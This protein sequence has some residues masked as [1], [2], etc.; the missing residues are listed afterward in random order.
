VL[1]MV[2]L[3]LDVTRDSGTVPQ[4]RQFIVV[5]VPVCTVHMQFVGTTFSQNPLVFLC[6]LFHWYPI[7][8]SLVTF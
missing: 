1:V 3:A 4:L 7:F 2:P 6:Q 5:R 8:T